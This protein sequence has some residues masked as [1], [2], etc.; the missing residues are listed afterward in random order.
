M[1]DTFNRIADL[2]PEKRAMLAKRLRT[3]GSAA[4]LLVAEPIAVIGLG[5]RFPGE[6][7]TPEAF[8][9]LLRDGVDAITEVPSDR[10][11]INAFYDPDPQAP[12]KMSTRWGGF[13]K[14]VDQFDPTFFGISPRETMNMDPQQRI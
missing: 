4:Q 1:D 11:D 7:N 13:I 9:E 8:W 12:G 10:W 5:C 6:A 2:S 14:H 3:T